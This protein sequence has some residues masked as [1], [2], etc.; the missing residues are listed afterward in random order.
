MKLSMRNGCVFKETKMAATKE[1][2]EER[3]RW[4]EDD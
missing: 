3:F 2:K 1:M 4:D